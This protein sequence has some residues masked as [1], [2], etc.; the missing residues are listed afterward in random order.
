V[1]PTTCTATPSALR[2]WASGWSQTRCEAGLVMRARGCRRL[3][4]WRHWHCTL[5]AVWCG[6]VWC[7]V[8][9]C[10]VVWCGVV[11]CGVVWC[12]V[13]WCGV[14]WCGVVCCPAS[15]QA[16]LPRH[17]LCTR[18]CCRPA[19]PPRTR[20]PRSSMEQCGI[21]PGNN[22]IIP[23]WSHV[24][25]LSTRVV[26][27][28]LLPDEPCRWACAA[29][30]VRMRA[31]PATHA[32]MRAS[33]HTCVHSSAAARLGAAARSARVSR[34]NARPPPPPPPAAP[35][36]RPLCSRRSRA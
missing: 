8:V 25:P 1:G 27:C 23:V 31:Q 33:H 6:V 34:P 13:V 17:D 21:K 3:E 5:G 12:G 36:G 9:W 28:L 16:A 10:G 18:A 35:T 7:G 24:Q 11:W 19:L 30:V 20:A 26:G 4:A 15:L 14:V 32:C 22:Y 2:G 29:R